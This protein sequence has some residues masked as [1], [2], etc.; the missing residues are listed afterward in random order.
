MNWIGLGRKSPW[1]NPDTI[2]EFGRRISGQWRQNLRQDGR[3]PGQDSNPAPPQQKPTSPVPQLGPRAHT[4]Q[5]CIAE[6]HGSNLCHPI[7]YPSRGS[8]G[9]KQDLLPYLYHSP[10]TITF[11]SNSTLHRLYNWNIENQ[12]TWR[13]KPVGMAMT[14]LAHIWAVPVRTS[15]SYCLSVCLLVSSQPN[16]EKVPINCV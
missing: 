2:P 14:G 7:S 5:T 10:L 15:D 1:P 6:V 8:S 11:Q 12:Q 4:L 16:A 3:S 9:R 13:M